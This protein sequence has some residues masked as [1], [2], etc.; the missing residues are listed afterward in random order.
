MNN[1][2]VSDIKRAQKTSLLFRTIAQ[3]FAQ[4][5]FDNKELTGFYVNRV[6]LSPDKGLCYVF[7]CAPGGEE[8]FKE[9]LPILKLY[10]PSVRA[11]IAKEVPGRYAPDIL[12]KFDKTDEKSRRIDDILYKL[13][14]N[15]D[16]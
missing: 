15:G 8:G 1:R 14:N 2:R 4:T 13:K 3:L 16:L 12:F 5:L 6:E 11:A 7:F 10:K 9:K